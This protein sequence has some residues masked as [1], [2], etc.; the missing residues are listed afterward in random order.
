MPGWLVV[1]MF[2]FN[3]CP[4]LCP[5][6]RIAQSKSQG[7]KDTRGH[8]HNARRLGDGQESYLAGGVEARRVPKVWAADAECAGW[9]DAGPIEESNR[10]AELTSN[11]TSGAK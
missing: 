11:V 10:P 4:L 3:L 6:Q 7:P 1:L 9:R 5:K 2:Y 8:N